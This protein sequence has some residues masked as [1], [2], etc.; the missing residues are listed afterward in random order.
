MGRCV[1]GRLAVVGELAAVDRSVERGDVSG[2]MFGGNDQC[3]GFTDR[4]VV[5][6][7]EERFCLWGSETPSCL[8][9]RRF[10]IRGRGRRIGWFGAL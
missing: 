9:M 6:V 10:C 4:R 5:R 7:P 8:V 1:E 2:S 3:E